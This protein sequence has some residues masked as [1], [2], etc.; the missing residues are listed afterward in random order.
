[1]F[2]PIANWFAFAAERM[3]EL[4]FRTGEHLVLTGISTGL[5]IVI[6]VPLGMLAASSSWLRSMVLGTIGIF[7]TIPSLALLAILL[8]AIGKIGVV[9]AV[10]ALVVYALL[11]I[12]R[13]TVTG[14]EGVST[15]VV[16]AAKGMGMTPWQQMLHVKLPLAMPIIVAGIRT[17]AVVGVGIATLSAFIGAG[18]L[19]QFINRGLAM[20]DTKLILLGAIPAA[21]L[22]LI[23]DSAIAATAWGIKPTRQHQKSRLV[24]VAKSAALGLPM[25]L[26]TFG[27]IAVINNSLKTAG[28]SG[29]KVRIGSKNFTEQLILGELMAQMIEAHTDLSVDRRFNL[30]G[31]MICHEALKAGEL[32]LYAEYTGTGLVTVLDQPAAPDADAVWD[33]VE[34]Q[35][36]QQFNLHWL[37]P[38]GFNNTYAL[39]V[40]SSVARK[41]D[42][43]SISNIVS[44]ADELK[45]GF[46]AEFSERADGY[47]GVSDTYGFRFSQVV[48][49]EPSLMYQAIARREVDVICAFTTDGRIEAYGLQTLEDDKEFFPPYFA[50][51]VIN[52]ALFEKHPEIKEVLGRLAGQIS[53]TEMQK[54]N[55]EVDERARQPEDVAREFL[56][57]KK[58][59]GKAKIN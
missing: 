38:F 3:A 42:W 13:N 57:D 29:S 43:Q 59:I 53:N 30:G 14:L 58:L 21:V 22:A 8:A 4:S 26:L 11:P 47:P 23:V 20:F 55:F 48:D 24:S 10:I 50:A 15:D 7:Q 54:M 44:S 17:A 32:D 31:T 36:R 9:P 52:P 18:G 1:M 45:A 37:K 27:V 5:A 25:L 16:E 19:G 12:A 40:R 41:N 51:P 34:S 46:T 49:L 33:T 6:G 56:I 2:E 39:A 35:Y 28:P